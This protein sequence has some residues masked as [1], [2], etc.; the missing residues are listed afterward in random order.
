MTT[1]EHLLAR[2]DSRTLSALALARAMRPHQWTKNAIVFAALV[3]GHQMFEADA[4]VR[5]AGAALAFCLMSSGVYLINDIRDIAHDRHHPRKR[6]RPVAAGQVSVRQATIT[7]AILAGTALVLAGAIAIPLVGVLAVYVVLM[8][9]YSMGLK[10]LVLIDVG[11][12]AGGFVL[13]AVAGAVA[14][15][16]P[17]SPWLYV[18]TALLAL[19]IGFGKRRAELSMLAHSASASRSSLQAYSLP[20]LDQLIGVVASAT[21]IAYVLYTFDAAAAPDS[22]AMMLTAPFVV[23]AMFRY[24]YLIHASDMSDTPEK[25]LFRDSPLLASIVGWGLFSVLILYVTGYD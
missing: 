20:L 11:V 25:L 15:D 10:H 3:F 22:H 18:C 13:R 16:V 14:I 23:Y 24:L 7:S 5:S 9:A 19:F 12:I 17:V 21:V 1:S 8:V 4:I 2:Q 6:Y